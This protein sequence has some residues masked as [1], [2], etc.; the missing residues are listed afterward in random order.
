M[1]P[2]IG[3]PETRA[4]I[5]GA[6]LI[7]DFLGSTRGLFG[8]ALALSA[9]PPEILLGALPGNPATLPERVLRA[10]SQTWDDPEHGCPSRVMVS[11]VIGDPEVGRLLKE[12]LEREMIERIAEQ[13]DGV[14]RRTPARRP[15]RSAPS[16]TQTW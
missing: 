11:L 2:W 6:A 7:S 5:L 14:V 1:H 16:P 9:N 15:A 10:L 12:V 3:R 8:A 4:Q 13:V